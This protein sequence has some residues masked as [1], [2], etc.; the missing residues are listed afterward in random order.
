MNKDT[1][2]QTEVFNDMSGRSTYLLAKEFYND[3]I[4]YTTMENEEY[5]NNQGKRDQETQLLIE[6]LVSNLGSVASCIFRDNVYMKV[7]QQVYDCDSD[8]DDSINEFNHHSQNLECLERVSKTLQNI[9]DAV[10]HIL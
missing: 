5:L 8:R 2:F 10:N 1:S 7:N 6:N 4:E 3:L 9:I